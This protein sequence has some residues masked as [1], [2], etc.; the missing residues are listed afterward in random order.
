MVAWLRP[1]KSV[2]GEFRRV[3]LVKS[4][5][6]LEFAEAFRP[7]LDLRGIL[8]ASSGNPTAE[9]QGQPITVDLAEQHRRVVIEVRALTFRNRSGG[10][11]LSLGR[12]LEERHLAAFTLQWM[13]NPVVLAGYLPANLVNLLTAGLV[14]CAI[15]TRTRST[16]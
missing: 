14:E 3:D 12:M 7:W 5:L 10:P 6:R 2:G 4:L 9:I 8:R 13:P 16:P 15:G 1:R 11:V